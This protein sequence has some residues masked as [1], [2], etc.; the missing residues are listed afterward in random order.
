MFEIRV[1][2]VVVDWDFRFSWVDGIYKGQKLGV[3][4]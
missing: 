1:G 2:D 3:Y 4:I